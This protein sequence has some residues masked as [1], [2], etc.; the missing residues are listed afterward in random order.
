MTA[1]TLL[2]L[3]HRRCSILVA[4]R[5]CRHEGLIFPVNI[6]PRCGWELSMAELPRRLRCSQCGGRE[7][8]VYEA[9]R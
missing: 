9:T 3:A 8:T 7:V 4:C 6:G 5:K 1:R 2:E